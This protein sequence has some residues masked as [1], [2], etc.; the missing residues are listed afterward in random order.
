M[1]KVVLWLLSLVLMLSAVPAGASSSRTPEEVIEQLAVPLAVAN[2][3]SVAVNPEYSAGE[4]AEILQ[5]L[6]E[7]GLTLADNNYL[8]QM[9]STGRGYNEEETIMEICRQIY[10]GNIMTWPLERQDWFERLTTQIGFTDT[11]TPRLPGKDNLTYEEAEAFAMQTVRDQFGKKLPLEDRNIWRLSRSFSMQYPDDPSSWAWSF[12]WE[13]K[14][15]DH[16]EYSVEFMDADP[17]GTVFFWATAPNWSEFYTGNDVINAFHAAY[18]WSEGGWSQETWHRFHELLQGADLNTES[19]DR[20]ELLAYRM[21]DYPLPEAADLS[22]EDAVRIAR[23]ALGV[24]LSGLNSAV[25]AAAEGRRLW[26]VSLVTAPENPGDPLAN[27]PLHVITLDSATGDVLSVRRAGEG[28][29]NSVAY[30]P[31]PVYDQSWAG[32]LHGEALLQ[33]AADAAKEQA[34]GLDLLNEELYSRSVFGYRYWFVDFLPKD[35]HLGK[36]SVKLELDGNIVSAEADTEPLTG[37]NIW[38][39]YRLTEGY[40][41]NWSQ[42]VWQ[43]LEKDLAP[44]EAKTLEGR[45]LKASRFPEES[46]VRI[47]RKDAWELA[48]LSIGS[49]KYAE[50]N[51]CILV[52]ADP[53]PVW[54][55]RILTDAPG[56]PVVGIDAETGEAVFT[57]VFRVDYT[58]VYVLYC[59]PRTWRKAELESLGA[60]HAAASAVAY[61]YGD[62]WQDDMD[63]HLDNTEE[64][65]TSSE[66]LLVR[67]TGRWKGMKSYEVELDENGFVLR[68]EESESSSEEERPAFPDIESTEGAALPPPTPT[69]GPDGRPWFW[70]MDFAPEAYWKQLEEHMEQLGITPENLKEKEAEWTSAYGTSEFW[71][72]EY[73]AIAYL[74]NAAP[75]WLSEPDFNYII[76]PDP[77]KKSREEI[78]AAA[79]VAFHELADGEQGAEWV[80]SLKA[81]LCL[82]S[83]AADPN[84]W[85]PFGKPVWWVDFNVWEEEFGV[86][87]PKG[88]VLLDEDGNVLFSE[89]DLYSN[90]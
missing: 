43:Q 63:L 16:G 47:G 26:I 29:S 27:P 69:P 5:A 38:S 17:A 45:L 56:D 76:F 84:T 32:I 50:I 30:V 12:S 7:S 59:T 87:N 75:E 55:M 65:E 20:Q 15:I 23:E 40:Y 41:G 22:R 82:Y 3:G 68:C 64:W 18:G 89:F 11:Y 13:P 14:D 81:S 66:G 73:Q 2:D 34:P 86:W 83:D 57:E 9:E 21:T 19:L 37:D 46:S 39:R 51:T 67:F 54:I 61:K 35:I 44:L 48:V 85:K 49:P 4:L 53:H 79:R 28:D 77:A 36:V 74:F 60:I 72:G 25:L 70:G 8:V 88:Y 52:D 24:S 42:S 58:P 10:G 78:E 71:P 31:E 33:K 1:K 62:L 80:D 6:R 90:G